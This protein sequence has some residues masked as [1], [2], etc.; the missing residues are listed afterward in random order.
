MQELVLHESKET[1][2]MQVLGEK[3]QR[4]QVEKFWA[5]RKTSP[6][7]QNAQILLP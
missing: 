7:L 5:V 3:H 6:D 2:N 4:R 1:K